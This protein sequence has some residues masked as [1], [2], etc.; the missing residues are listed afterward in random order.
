MFFL[1]GGSSSVAWSL[2]EPQTPGNRQYIHLT[3]LVHFDYIFILFRI[4]TQWF[5]KSWAC[6]GCR[7]VR[8]KQRR[9]LPACYMGLFNFFSTSGWGKKSIWCPSTGSIV[10]LLKLQNQVCYA[11]INHT[12]KQILTVVSWW[13]WP[14]SHHVRSE[15]FKTERRWHFMGVK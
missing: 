13:F 10:L 2:P 1:D 8:K 15:G 11:R 4:K 7:P 3:F 5:V 12:P 6:L 9:P 14:T